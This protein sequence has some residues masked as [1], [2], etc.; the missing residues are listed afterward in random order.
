MHKSAEVY[1]YTPVTVDGAATFG[2]RIG[3]TA[4]DLFIA[5]ENPSRAIGSR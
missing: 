2:H 5:D 3:L 1:T 4:N